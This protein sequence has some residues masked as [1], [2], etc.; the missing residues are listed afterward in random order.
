MSE[1]TSNESPDLPVT[2]REAK[3]NA[4]SNRKVTESEK[5]AARLLLDAS[6]PLNE[7]TAMLLTDMKSRKT[8][9]EPLPKI[10]FRNLLAR[11]VSLTERVDLDEEKPN[12]PVDKIE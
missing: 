5:V 8:S 4:N 11:K 9:E 3:L 6:P 2:G 12:G 1:E 10:D 7:T